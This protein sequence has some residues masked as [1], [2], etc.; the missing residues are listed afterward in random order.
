MMLN[1]PLLSIFLS[2]FAITR[3]EDEKTTCDEKEGQLQLIGQSPSA[4]DDEVYDKI[5]SF[6]PQI[7]F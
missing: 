7:W 3:L 6:C 1:I 4:I 5:L 2:V